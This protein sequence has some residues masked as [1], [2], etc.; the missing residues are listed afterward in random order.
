[1]TIV[2]VL[3]H[4]SGIDYDYTISANK[5]RN[6]VY[7]QNAYH[8]MNEC[9]MYDGVLPFTVTFDIA[10]QDI[11]VVFHVNGAGRYRVNK[12]G[13][14]EYLQDIYYEALYNHFETIAKTL[15]E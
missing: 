1:M 2:N 9:G 12:A 14:K 4:G 11:K 5:K 7:A 3:P 8:Y 13:L 10:K 15:N 6:K